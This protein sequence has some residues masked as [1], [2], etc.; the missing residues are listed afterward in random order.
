[1]ATDWPDYALSMLQVTSDSVD[2]VNSE[3]DVAPQFALGQ[4]SGDIAVP[5]PATG[6]FAPRFPGRVQTHFEQRGE[7]AGRPSWDLHLIRT[8]QEAE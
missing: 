3:K 5:D 1:M 8:A 2:F 4:Y 6:G 7:K